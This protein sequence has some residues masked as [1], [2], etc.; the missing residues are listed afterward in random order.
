M[1]GGSELFKEEGVNY[2][3][4]M[5]NE[6]FTYALVRKNNDKNMFNLS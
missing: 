4:F 2:T 3:K 1:R 5:R 6:R